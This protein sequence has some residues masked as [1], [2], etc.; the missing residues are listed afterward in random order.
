VSFVVKAQPRSQ[1]VFKP[2][3]TVGPVTFGEVDGKAA[4]TTVTP[5]GAE[6]EPFSPT[7]GINGLQ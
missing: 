7:S 4:F 2:V 1:V 6:E 5:L 3:E